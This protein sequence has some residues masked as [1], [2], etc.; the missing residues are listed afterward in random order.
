MKPDLQQQGRLESWGCWPGREPF[1]TELRFGIRGT[2]N[3]WAEVDA[4][5]SSSWC[6]ESGGRLRTITMLVTMAMWASRGSRGRLWEVEGKK[7]R[8]GP[9]RG[10]KSG[11]NTGGPGGRKWEKLEE[12]QKHSTQSLRAGCGSWLASIQLSI[13]QTIKL[14]ATNS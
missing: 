10:R 1:E 12:K 7:G 3:S 2:T 8:E 4:R 14:T 13:Y 6:T 11:D 5:A 9:D